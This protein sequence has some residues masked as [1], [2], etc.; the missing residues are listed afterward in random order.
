MG[1]LPLS[2]IILVFTG[3]INAGCFI[4]SSPAPADDA[5]QIFVAL[6]LLTV[7]G[8]GFGLYKLVFLLDELLDRL[9]F[10]EHPF[11]QDQQPNE[12]YMDLYDALLEPKPKLDSLYLFAGRFRKRMRPDT[13]PRG[14][15]RKL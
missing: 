14:R 3:V 11:L 15:K 1:L 12:A 7:F 5:S 4:T 8:T 10:K 13:W 6:A 9:V 2:F